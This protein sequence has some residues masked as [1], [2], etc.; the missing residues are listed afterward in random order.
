MFA[1]AKLLFMGVF[2]ND[3]F[4][5][6]EV[7]GGISK[8]LSE[9]PSLVT[10]AIS[11]IVTVVLVFITWLYLRETKKMREIAYESL[12]VDASPKVFVSSLEIAH[13]LNPSTRKLILTPICKIRNVGKT[14]A[15]RIEISYKVLFNEETQIEWQIERAPYIFPTQTFKFNAV[16]FE[17]ILEND[18]K[19]AQAKD[20]LERVGKVLLPQNFSPQV[21]LNLTIKYF[22]YNDE[23]Q[24][25]S[26]LAVYSWNHAGWG[27]RIAEEAAEEEETE[28]SESPQD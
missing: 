2:I 1:L 8:L 13:G 5:N 26:Y 9:N 24:K 28:S 21:S 25:I 18:E 11:T 14:E 16:A 23:E 17:I 15:K 12:Q 3:V 10:A 22:D 4:L 6:Q 7:K 19:V 20:I 27:L